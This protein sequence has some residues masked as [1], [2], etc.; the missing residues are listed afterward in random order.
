MRTSNVITLILLSFSLF[1]FSC[2][3]FDEHVRPSGDVTTRNESFE[4]YNAINTSH[5]FQVYVNFSD[6][7]EIIEIE[8]N[9]NLHQHIEVKLVN[10]TLEIGLRDNI[11]IRGSATLKAY[12]TTRHVSS[13]SGSG[14]SRFI[15]QSPIEAENVNIHLSGASNFSGDI[16][17]SELIVDLSG[18]SVMN[19]SGISNEF[20]IEASGASVC[21][22]FGF[23][24]NYLK[25]DI[26]GASGLYL[27][28]NDEIDVEASG[29]SN[30]HYKGNAVIS[31][32]DMS[33][34][35]T[36]KKIY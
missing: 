6:T 8:A 18:A 31:H 28:I 24:T 30:L 3:V 29:A 25:A 36:I 7:E 23:E 14:A 34:A 15:N 33:G 26:S 4:N 13:F 2:N 11:S 19:I 21:R 16:Q 12:I 5:A 27:T 1:L 20:D 22:D 17:T 10:N 35:S 9:D 32:Q